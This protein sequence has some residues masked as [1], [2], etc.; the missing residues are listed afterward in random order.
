[1]TKSAQKN[2]SPEQSPVTDSHT[3][4]RIALVQFIDSIFYEPGVAR[5]CHI[6]CHESIIKDVYGTS[7]NTFRSYLKFPP[8]RLEGVELPPQTKELLRLYVPL[9]KQLLAAETAASLRLLNRQVQ[10][11]LAEMRRQGIQPNARRLMEAIRTADESYAPET[12]Q[13]SGP[14]RKK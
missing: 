5:W 4:Y 1:M 11:E 9:T 6:R 3:L 7:P 13:R 12:E 14:F 2:P 10:T 8:E